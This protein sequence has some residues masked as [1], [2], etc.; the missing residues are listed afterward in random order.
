MVRLSLS[1]FTSLLL[2]S[3]LPAQEGRLERV[4]R[5]VNEQPSGPPPTAGPVSPADDDEASHGSY[6]SWR[7]EDGD[8]IG[9]FVLASGAYV[10]YATVAAPFVIPRWLLDD[11]GQPLYFPRHPYDRGHPGYLA[12][13]VDA[14][15][16][17]AERWDGHAPPRWWMAR[18]AIEDGNDFDG[19]NRVGGQFLFDTATRFGVV[20][21]WDHYHETFGFG[22][23]HDVTTIGDVTLLCRFAQT[24]HVLM[25]AGVGCR[26]MSDEHATN[27]GVNLH[28]G[29]EWFPC[30][31]WVVS[32]G[33]DFGNLGSAFVVRARATAG[34]LWHGLEAFAGYD[35]LRIGEVNLHGPMLGVRFWF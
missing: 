28:Y 34:V 4:R 3:A 10:F 19:L 15:Q 12:F 29:G 11:H 22:Q 14:S 21:N 35:F 2:L 5:E 1:L 17:A 20:T 32:A 13:D 27:A 25:R 8:P 18:V 23:G 26:I 6:G 33:M 24:E 16:Q 30:E 31:P 7:E 9:D